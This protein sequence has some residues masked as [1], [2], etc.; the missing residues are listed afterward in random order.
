MG[1]QQVALSGTGLQYGGAQGAVGPVAGR[2]RK[3]KVLAVGPG[4]GSDTELFTGSDLGNQASKLK[5]VIFSLMSFSK[6]SLSSCLA[7]LRSSASV[8]F[9]RGFRRFS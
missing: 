8:F 9:L 2:D 1:D 6:A 5:S 7:I 3:G 4:V